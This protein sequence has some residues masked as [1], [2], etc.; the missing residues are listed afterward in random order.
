MKHESRLRTEFLDTLAARLAAGAAE[1]G[2]ASFSRP[3][4]ETTA[5]ILDEVLDVA[6]WAYVLW[7]Q[8]RQRLEALELAATA[9]D[10]RTPDQ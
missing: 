8:M 4:P 3:A 10:I 1:Y 7:V 5:E 9:L 6:G 2:N